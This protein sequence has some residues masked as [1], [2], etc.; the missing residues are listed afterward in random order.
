MKRR[1][2]INTIAATTPLA[3]FPKTQSLGDL[4]EN[5]FNLKYKNVVRIKI[6]ITLINA[7]K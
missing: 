5:K 7:V 2:F 4:F 1:G 3:V 6:D